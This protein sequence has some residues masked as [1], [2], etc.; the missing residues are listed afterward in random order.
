MKKIDCF[1]KLKNEKGFMSIEAIMAMA[2][3]LM[4]VLLGV[5]L[6]TYMMPRQAIEEEVH[7]L[8]RTAKMQGGL[9]DGDVNQFKENMK[10]RGM[11]E[12]EN[13]DDVKVTL[14]L[15]TT[16]GEPFPLEGYNQDMVGKSP[17]PRG[18]GKEQVGQYA[19]MK[20]RVEV[21]ANKAGLSGAMSFFGGDEDLPDAYVFSERVMSEYYGVTP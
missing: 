7:L 20:V 8:G 10:K 13:L 5:G 9:T 18:F 11:V 6:F 4:I 17:I 12:D 14:N 1:R 21:P 2:T 16:A 19:V 3:I 15:E